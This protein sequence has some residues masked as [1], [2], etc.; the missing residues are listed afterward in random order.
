MFQDFQW[1]ILDLLSGKK[2]RYEFKLHIS[3]EHPNSESRR[4]SSSESIAAAST[5]DPPDSG[6]DS[7]TEWEERRGGDG[8]DGRNTPLMVNFCRPLWFFF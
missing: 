6:N 7:G 4:R 3:I 5:V 2:L 8:L 1:I